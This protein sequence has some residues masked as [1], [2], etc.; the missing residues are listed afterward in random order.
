MKR[1]SAVFTLF[2]LPGVFFKSKANSET[3]IQRPPLLKVCLPPVEAS[4]KNN[5]AGINPQDETR[6]SNI[7]HF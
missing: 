5:N 6:L 4:N 7:C 3:L 1:K 2:L